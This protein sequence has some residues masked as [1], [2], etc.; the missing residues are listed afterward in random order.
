M[1]G[2]ELRAMRR[3]IGTVYQQ[4]YLVP[5]LTALENTLSGRL[6]HWSL[7]ETIRSAVRPSKREK[8]RAMAALEAVGLADKHQ[9]RADQLS[10]GQQQ[11]LAI[12]RVLM[13]DPDV[14]LADEPFASL[15]PARTETIA[16]LLIGLVQGGKLTL[17]VTLHDVE[18]ALRYFPRIIALRDGRVVFDQAP[19]SVNRQALDALYAG[20]ATPQGAGLS[21]RSEAKHESHRQRNCAR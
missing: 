15:D 5:A 17:V 19:E 2:R 21:E 8:E 16:A 11:R 6:G 10:S 14:I 13:Q 18:L 4:H 7:L 9:S 3:R 20:N 1:S 12:A